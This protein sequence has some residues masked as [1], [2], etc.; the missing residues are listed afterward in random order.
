MSLRG[1]VVVMTGA[2]SGI[3]R[4]ASIRFAARGAR[5]VLAARRL[6]ALEEVAV[7]CR[8]AGGEAIVRATDVCNYVGGDINGGLA[9]IGQLLFRPVTRVDPYATALD[10]VFLC[11]SS[12]PP[13]GGVHGMCG[14][15][16]AHSVL[17][18]RFRDLRYSALGSAWDRLAADGD[19]IVP[20]RSAAARA[21]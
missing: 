21:I 17:R 4:A 16:A 14:Y 15:W 9:D 5:V 7:E 19:V 6:A 8:A 1:K 11:S 12:T 10:D 3:G 13:G 20:D 18:N 2:S